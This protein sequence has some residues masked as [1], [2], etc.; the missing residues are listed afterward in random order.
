MKAKKNELFSQEN[1][2]TQPEYEEVNRLICQWF[3][4]SQNNK[5]KQLNDVI[6]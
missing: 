2:P 6:F 5:N 4:C 1:G 3:Q